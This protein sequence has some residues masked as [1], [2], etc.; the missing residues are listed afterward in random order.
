MTT[1]KGHREALRELMKFVAERSG[2]HRELEFVP[3]PAATAMALQG[4]ELDEHLKAEAGN[5]S[6]EELDLSQLVMLE[7]EQLMAVTLYFD[8]GDGA[9]GHQVLLRVA[10]REGDEEM[11]TLLDGEQPSELAP[12]SDSEGAEQTPSRG[13]M[14]CCYKISGTIDVH[15]RTNQS[16]SQEDLQELARE[17]ARGGNFYWLALDDVATGGSNELSI[18]VDEIQV[19]EA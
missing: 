3:I 9:A 10:A 6:W 13:T 11:P 4:I 2:D 19:E 16:L 7:R 12:A 17:V 14:R 8:P 18:E 5:S 1:Y 15:W